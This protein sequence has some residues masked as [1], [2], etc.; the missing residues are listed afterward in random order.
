MCSHFFFFFFNPPA[1]QAVAIRKNADFR[2]PSQQ[3]EVQHEYWVRYRNIT[4]VSEIDHRRPAPQVELLVKSTQ[5]GLSS[6]CFT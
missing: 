5:P 6:S 2:S 3:G 4:L 1:D